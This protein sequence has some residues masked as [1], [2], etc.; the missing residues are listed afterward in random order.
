MIKKIGLAALLLA[1]STAMAGFTASVDVAQAFES[2]VQYDMGLR[3][4]YT[5]SLVNVH[6]TPEI[7]ERLLVM[8]DDIDIGTFFG[9]RLSMGFAVAPGVFFNTGAWT[10]GQ[11][12][13]S[14]GGLT[15]DFRAIP[16]AVVGLHAG[17]T[18]HEGGDFA[19]AGAHI[20]VEF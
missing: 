3:A 20:G 8:E 4:G 2:P 13:S 6:L 1:P 17:Y 12:T 7:S 14:T 18:L 10:Y 15:L 19:S 11:T 5:I 9:A 16:M